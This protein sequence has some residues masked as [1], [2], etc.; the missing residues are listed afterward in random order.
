M[1]KFSEIHFRMLPGQV[2]AFD[3][4]ERIRNNKDVTVGFLKK[5]GISVDCEDE[6]EVYKAMQGIAHDAV[7][8]GD[9]AETQIGAEPI[10]TA[11]QFLQHF[12]NKTI[13]VATEARLLDQWIGRTV[14][15]KWEDEEII[16]PVNELTSNIREYSDE[17]DPLL[18][19]YKPGVFK[20]TIVRFES[21]LMTG[22]LAEMRTAAMNIRISE[23]D[24]KRAAITLGF[25]INHND[26]GLFGY[27]NG[28]NMTYGMLN[29]ENLP[30]YITVANGASSDSKWST[31]KYLEIV[32]DLIT[33]AAAL[34]VRSGSLF[35]A[36]NDSFTLAVATDAID[37]LDNVSEVSQNT[38][39]MDWIRKTW[40]KCRVIGIP[41]LSGANGGENVFYMHM[42]KLNGDYV[43]DQFVPTTL[44]LLGMEKRAKGVLEDYTSATAGVLVAQPTGIIR[45]S[46]I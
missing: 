2:Q 21:A 38:S 36:H 10:S 33:A 45:Y 4:D 28:E 25:A 29:D 24:S 13:T 5:L 32:R 34:R 27:N 40:P 42:D 20:R 18:V 22:K 44:K 46:G 41:Q 17:A 16:Q 19:N 11:L 23:Y 12:L 6:D 1:A 30:G 26:I 9:A 14:A 31:K 7:A 15:G 37:Y 39:V 35:D 3:M 43:V 8:T